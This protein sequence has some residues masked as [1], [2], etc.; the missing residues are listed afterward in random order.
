MKTPSTQNGNIKDLYN[1]TNY[2]LP[3]D[4]DKY[5]DMGYSHF[6]IQGRELTTCQLFAEFFPYIIRP[7]FYPM[8]ISIINAR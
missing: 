3:Q 8:A 1:G 7:D 6:K 4:L 5:L 2:I